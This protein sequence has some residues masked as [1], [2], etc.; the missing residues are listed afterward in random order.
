MKNSMWTSYYMDLSPEG[1]VEEIARHGWK[2]AELSDEHGAVL[3]ERGDPQKAG[4]AFRKA[5]ENAGV[6]I[7]QGHLWLQV[8]LCDPDRERIVGWYSRPT[9]CFLG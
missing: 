5:A 3:L 6:R 2:Y 4:R 9:A 1:A 7:E 8:P